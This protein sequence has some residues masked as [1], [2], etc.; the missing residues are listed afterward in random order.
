MVVARQRHPRWW[1]CW[2]LGVVTPYLPAGGVRPASPANTLA[3][4]TRL[5]PAG[6]AAPLAR[7]QNTP[8]VFG[9]T[10]AN[11]IGNG[12]WVMFGVFVGLL[13]EYATGELSGRGGLCVQASWAFAQHGRMRPVAMRPAPAEGPCVCE[14]LAAASACLSHRLGLTCVTTSALQAWTSPTSCGSCS[15]TWASSTQSDVLMQNARTHCHCCVGR[16]AQRNACISGWRTAVQAIERHGSGT[17]RGS[18]AAEAWCGRRRR[19]STPCMRRVCAD[20]AAALCGG[21]LAVADWRRVRVRREGGTSSSAIGG[22]PRQAGRAGWCGVV[23]GGPRVR[24]SMLSKPFSACVAAATVCR[25]VPLC[26]HCVVWAFLQS[27][28]TPHRLHFTAAPTLFVLLAPGSR[29]GGRGYA[30]C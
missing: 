25:S 17:S 18:R 7:P 1:R 11:E 29:T 9:W 10:P 12:R 19:L 14:P 15:A 20:A 5:D 16:C 27:P 2:P 24:G 6:R 26:L 23:W 30:A 8:R 28:R 22:A 21:W 4:H 13:T 3:A